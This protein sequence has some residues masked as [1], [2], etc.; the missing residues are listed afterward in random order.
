MNFKRNVKLPKHFI[1]DVDGV[2]TDG[3]F[4]YSEDGK[5]IKAFGVDDHDALKYISNFLSIHTISADSSGF[6]ITKKRIVDHMKFPLDLVPV[7]NREKWI[8]DRFNLDECIYMGDGLFDPAI[9]N[10]VMYSMTP[11][12]ALS[13]TKRK[14]NF[15]TKS[16]G[17]DRAVAEAC[18]HLLEKF[19]GVKAKNI[20]N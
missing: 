9:F 19:F 12:N 13:A 8:Q 11:N 6:S 10:V 3:K 18:M 15:V 20:Y 17:G 2:L 1:I 7:E 16:N 5:I 4:Y 14:A